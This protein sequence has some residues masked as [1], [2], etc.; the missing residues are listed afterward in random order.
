MVSHAVQCYLGMQRKNI[1]GN[2]RAV[3]ATESYRKC[4]S[5]YDVPRSDKFIRARR[6]SV[7]LGGSWGKQDKRKSI[8]FTLGIINIL[9][10][11]ALTTAPL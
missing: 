1:S 2:Y 3:S 8:D 7:D 11:M 5:L 4:G 6:R 10:L 9:S